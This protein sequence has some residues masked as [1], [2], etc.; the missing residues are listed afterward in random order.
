MLAAHTWFKITMEIPTLVHVGKS[1]KY[2]KAPIPDF[3]L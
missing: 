2:L 3:I 1:L